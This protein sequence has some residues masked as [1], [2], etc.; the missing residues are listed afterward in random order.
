[1]EKGQGIILEE[2]QYEKVPGH[3]HFRL[4][5]TSTVSEVGKAPAATATPTIDR[6]KTSTAATTFGPASTPGS[7]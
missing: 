5:F 2:N 4:Q 3:G 7:R 1:M 6:G